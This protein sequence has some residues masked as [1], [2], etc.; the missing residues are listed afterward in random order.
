MARYHFFPTNQDYY[1]CQEELG[2]INAILVNYARIKK[3][4]GKVT[5]FE[6]KKVEMEGALKMLNNAMTDNR[7]S[8]RRRLMLWTPNIENSRRWPKG[9]Q[10]ELMYSDDD[11]E[12]DG[13]LAGDAFMHQD[14]STDLFVHQDP[15][16]NLPPVE[17]LPTGHELS[18]DP[19]ETPSLNLYALVEPSM[20]HHSIVDPPISQDPSTE[21]PLKGA[22]EWSS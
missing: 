2:A 11:E 9:G 15:P 20:G 22:T 4:K 6:V 7:L 13:E 14:L 1:E 18:H 21:P 17:D 10:K 3:L 8:I 19:H 16:T 12:E 5:K